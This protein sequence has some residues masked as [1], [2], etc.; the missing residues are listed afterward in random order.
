MKLEKLSYCILIYCLTGFCFHQDCYSQNTRNTTIKGSVIDKKTREPL[1][2]VSV[3]L[4]NTTTGT[5]TDKKGDYN[6]V[7]A[8]TSYKIQFSF[9]GYE[10]EERIISPGKTQVINVELT[11]STYELNEIVIK[12][13]KKHYTN[14]NNPAVELIDKVI[15]NKKLNRME[16]L[17]YFKYNKYEKLVFS[18]SNL[19]ENFKKP[20]LFS[21]FEFVLENV[22]STRQDGK[23]SIPFFIKETQ[24]D[25]YYRKNPKAEKEIVR[26]EKTIRFDEYIDSKGI[27][28]N[29]KYLYQNINIYDNEIFFLSNK[30][31]SPVSA[32]AP[33]LYRYFIIDTSLV[34]NVKCIKL[35]FE[36]RNP[37][38]FLFHGF[39]Y[40]I[41]DSTYAIKKIDMSFN[42]GI[43]IDWVND[44]RIVQEFSR[45]QDKA[46][47]LTKDEVSVDFGLSQNIL[48]VYGQKVV[49]YNNYSVNEPIADTIFK[50][51]DKIT[52][53]DESGNLPSYWEAARLS[54]LTG[55]EK[56]LYTIVDSVK[57]IPAF[58]H[59]MDI[60]MLLTTD[61]FRIGKFETGPIGSFYSYNQ[62]EGSRL[63]FGGRT[64][65]E[66][67]RWI[68]F[69]S[70]LAY[71]LKD[72]QMKYNLTATYSLTGKSIYKFPVKSI[73]LSYQ[74]DTQTPGQVLEYSTK[75]NLFLSLKRGQDNSQFYNRTLR[76]E[77]LNEYENHFSYTVGYDF[78]KQVPEG[79]LYFT[80]N[81]NLPNVNSVPFLNISEIYLTLRYAPKEQFYQ[82]K[83]YRY[84]VPSKYPVLQLESSIGSKS[85][86]SDYNY[87]KIKFSISKR[88]YLSI[89]GY[90]DVTA[91]AGKI[92]GSVSYPLLFIHNANQTYVY[93]K[94]SYNM[95]NFLEFVSDR[96]FALNIDHS[97][98]GFFFNK[99][100]LLKKLKFREVMTCKVLFGGVN[101]NNNP[102]YNS[103]LF[104]FPTDQNGIPVTFALGQK[105]YVEASIG[106][107]NILRIF[108]VDIIK[109]ITYINHPDVL[110]IGIRAQFKFDI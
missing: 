8:S 10:T 67:N 54:P 45:I 25:Y 103:N 55:S 32:R 2:F 4:E 71:G 24:A 7:T 18:V 81:R 27:S 97:F 38:D 69:D 90:T 35:F 3:M 30:F 11:P 92:F 33:I 29:L 102:D 21:K 57:K 82:G 1:P 51:P 107:S 23:K 39:L 50:G 78:I 72:R 20:K 31:L 17:D 43:N 61:Y 110:T 83:L 100:P 19:P 75:D 22:D 60:I 14:K 106:V 105:P 58:R 40:I 89:I 46:W 104:M 70:Y 80:T 64:T 66:F 5:T 77:Y 56:K 42:K 109:R 36:P 52:R 48:G 16:G 98:N 108:R 53:L 94:N 6:I 41:N 68:Y 101:R 73:K 63:R 74:Y 91:E 95:M 84:P 62:I 34:S 79:N 76:L 85:L 88:F 13:V 28:A 37:A 44:V 9:I 87:Q 15:E 47:L 12:P 49:D 26:A 65:P 59:R 96:Y 99:V 86:S 93:Q